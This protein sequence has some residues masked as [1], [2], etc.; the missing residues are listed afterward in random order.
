MLTRI[1]FRRFRNLVDATWEPAPGALLLYGGNGAGKTSLLEAIYVLATTRSFRASRLTECRRHGEAGF[2]LQG[3]VEGAQRTDLAVAWEAGG[4]TRAV[5][6]SAGSLAE[7]LG[8]QPVVSWTAADGELLGGPPS[9]RRRFLDQGII[10]MRPAAIEAV[11]RYR[12]ALE[13]KRELVARRGRG[14]EAWNEVLAAAAVELV[15]LRAAFV[16]ALAAEL[17]RVIAASGVEL[18][19]VTLSYRPSPKEALEGTEAL[20]RALAEVSARELDTGMAL[21]GPHRDELEIRWGDHALKTTASAG[22]RK[23][24]GLA[25]TAA[26]AAVLARLERAPLVLLDDLDAELDPQ[27]LEA[28]WWLFSGAGQVVATTSRRELWERLEVSRAWSVAKGRIGPSE[29]GLND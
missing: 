1:T 13:Q 19:P 11:A 18:P 9:V 27:R 25:L 7:H 28:A 22:E 12:R 5:N 15:S 16:D 21:L 24:V 20:L 6:Q 29:G 8:V 23:L 4:R 14:L 26:R 17:E 3:R 2:E 10:G